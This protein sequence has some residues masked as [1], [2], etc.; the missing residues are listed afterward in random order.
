MASYYRMQRRT[1]GLVGMLIAIVRLE[2]PVRQYHRGKLRSTMNAK[3]YIVTVTP[4]RKLIK[5][6]HPTSCCRTANAA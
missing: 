2:K 1:K 5:A 3:P 6:A 4:K